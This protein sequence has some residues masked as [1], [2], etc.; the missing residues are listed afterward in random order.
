MC[1]RFEAAAARCPTPPSAPCRLRLLRRFH[2]RGPC[3]RHYLPATTSAKDRIRQGSSICE[4]GQ[5]TGAA[6]PEVLFR[7]TSLRGTRPRAP[8]HRRV[9]GRHVKRSTRALGLARFITPPGPFRSGAKES[10]LGSC[11]GLCTPV[12]S[13]NSLS[14]EMRVGVGW[15]AVHVVAQGATPRA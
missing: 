12:G 4:Q 9:G 10:P 6:P 2:R 11:W 13:R 14:D 1:P 15:I 8:P 7:P 3:P 5:G